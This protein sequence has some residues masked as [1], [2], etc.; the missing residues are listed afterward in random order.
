MNVQVRGWFTGPFRARVRVLTVEA[1]ANPNAEQNAR[2]LLEEC[3]WN[4]ASV[5]PD[6]STFTWRDLE[7]DQTVPVSERAY[8][9]YEVTT[10][11][12]G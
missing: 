11:A 5:G 1:E 9:Y 8:R 7:D 10:E 6:F 2:T 3:C 12:V 4:E